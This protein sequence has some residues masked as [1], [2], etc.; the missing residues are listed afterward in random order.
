MGRPLAK[1]ADSTPGIATMRSISPGR[2]IGSLTGMVT[3]N[4]C[5]E[6]GSLKPGATERSAATLRTSK[7][8]PST[9]TSA[10]AT[11]ATTSPERARW[12][13]RPA[14][15]AR[16]VPRRSPA[17]RNAGRR[18]ALKQRDARPR[19]RKRAGTG[20]KRD[21]QALQH[22]PARG[23]GGSGAQRDADGEVLAARLGAD[24]EKIE[25]VRASQQQQQRRRAHRRPKLA[26]GAADDHLAE[27]T[28]QGRNAP[29]GQ[30]SRFGFGSAGIGAEPHR[31][32]ALQIVRGGGA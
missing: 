18:K 19:Q 10:S 15:A 1:A 14:V 16:S 20:R 30:G 23:A 27:R 21:Q 11:W 8:A 22:D 24:E 29:P 2:D 13:S 32:Q 4:V 31:K 3:R 17:T 5:S 9:N 25:H 7:P 26:A 12:L 6:A 28:D